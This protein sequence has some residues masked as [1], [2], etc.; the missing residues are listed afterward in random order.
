MDICLLNTSRIAYFAYTI[1]Y[2]VPSKKTFYTMSDTMT[3]TW[4]VFE[5]HQHNI[6]NLRCFAKQL[7]NFIL[8]RTHLQC[9]QLRLSIWVNLINVYLAASLTVSFCP[10]RKRIG[11]D[12]FHLSSLWDIYRQLQNWRFLVAYILQLHLLLFWTDWGPRWLS[13]VWDCWLLIIT[14]AK[15]SAIIVI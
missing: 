14:L 6:Q 15:S 8:T 4:F 2:S 9:S 5:K 7:L 10:V 11:C 13:I 1:I 12:R 3:T